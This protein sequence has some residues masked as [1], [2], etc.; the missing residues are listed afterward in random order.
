[1]SNYTP[2]IP[3]GSKDLLI[4]G[5]PLKAIKGADLT[6]EFAA[7]QVA[8]NSKL[9][10]GNVVI[11]APSSGVSLAVTG[12]SALTTGQFVETITQTSTAIGS[13][14]LLVTSSVAPQ[15]GIALINTVNSALTFTELALQ[16]GSGTD[17]V[18]FS[19]TNPSWAANGFGISGL[20]AG[21]TGTLSSVPGTNG[22]FPMAICTNNTVQI[23]VAANGNISIKGPLGVNGASPPAQVTGW[24]TPTGPAVVAN[25]SGTAATTLQMQ[26][27][28]AQIITALK[29]V[30]IF[31]A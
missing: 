28:I 25:F 10:A 22:A 13:S 7:V 30:G 23:L 31:G 2:V 3:F 20:P 8:V 29:A 27:A 21:Q 14:G 18:S 12:S 16:G 17:N 19:M 24:G 1:M 6:T 11:P 5:N 4:S 9:D 15:T 26:N